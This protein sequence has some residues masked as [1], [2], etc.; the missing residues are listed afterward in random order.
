MCGSE[1]DLPMT[2]CPVVGLFEETSSSAS[3]SQVPAPARRRPARV[4][5]LLPAASASAPASCMWWLGRC[6]SKQW[7]SSE[8]PWSL[9]V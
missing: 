1:Q 7:C 6:A 4:A 9:R 3:S 2:A 5:D 8:A